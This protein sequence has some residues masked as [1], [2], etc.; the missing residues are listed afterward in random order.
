LCFENKKIVPQIHGIVSKRFSS[1]V[2]KNKSSLSLEKNDK[3]VFFLLTFSAN[4]KEE[5]VSRV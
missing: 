5:N 2:V 4:L 3:R 1:V